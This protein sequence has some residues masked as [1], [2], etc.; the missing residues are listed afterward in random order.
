MFA[1][2]FRKFSMKHLSSA[3][4]IL[5]ML[6]WS[7]EA[8]PTD[9]TYV[10]GKVI[11]GKGYNIRLMAYNDLVSYTRVTLDNYLIGDDESFTLKA[12]TE[13]V[14]YCWLDLEFQQAEIFLQP[15]QSY[16]VETEL[17]DKSLTGSY[18]NRTS[19]PVRFV[20]DDT[21]HLNMSIQ[22]FNQLYN[23]FLLSYAETNQQRNAKPAFDNFIN[24]I[25]IRFQNNSN[26]F[27]REYLRYKTASMQL[28]LRL[29]SRD[30][31]GK[32]YLSSYQVLYDNPE[33]MD[34]FHLFFEKYF[35]TGGKY[36]TFNKTYDLVNGN[37]GFMEITDSLKA[38]PVLTDQELRELLLL[39]GL[40]ELYNINGFRRARVVSLIREMSV[41]S[42]YETIRS[43]AGNLLISL[44]RL[45]NGSEAP[46]FSLPGVST[47][48]VY[49]LSD[50][51]GKKLY[52][53]FFGSDNPA[54]QSELGL[55]ADFY[56]DYK[57]NVHFVAVS[58]DKDIPA[59]KDYLARAQLPWLVL[60][61]N[62]DLSLLENYDASSF[63]HFVLI[64]P[65]GLIIRCPAPSPS[66]NIQKL[67]DSN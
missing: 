11:N 67:F 36:F 1:V 63:P 32:E 14:L 49:S 41:N 4:L 28:Y 20:S 21:D 59:L 30:N 29:K 33:Y 54:S 42:G 13:N 64:N 65:Q 7:S 6:A 51:K 52:L 3:L 38:D 37:A 62:G 19:L 22:D 61:Y 56:E 18:Y 57:E 47:N 27:F 9:T 5:L 15:G 17:R 48:G 12:V 25:E 2:I 43:L 46:G 66:E 24:A 53:A 31:I 55:I 8:F 44:R 40:K 60:H 35:I 50:F 58:V 23:D 10:R 39:T 45:Q 16:E 26:P 34:F